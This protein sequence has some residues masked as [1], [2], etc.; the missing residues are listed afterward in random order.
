M[1]SIIVPAYNEEKAISETIKEIKKAMD[2]YEYEI[3]VI[4]DCSK[5]KTGAILTEVKGIRV[6]NHP[7]N[8]GYGS[9]IKSGI[10][11]AKGDW[12]FITDAD[13]TYPIRDM[14]KLI[15]YIKNYD[16]V[17]GSR[18][19]KQVRIPLLRKPAKILLNIL[20]RFL[21][22]KK[23]PDLN[24]GLRIFK[25][26]IALEFFHLFPSKFSFTTT[27]T[28]A[29]LT[30][31]YT[32]KYIPIEYY[33]RKG[34][35]SIK[36][37]DFVNFLT[38]IT[39]IITYFKPFKVFFLFSAIL[40]FIAILVFLYTGIVLNKIMDITVIVLLIASLQIFLWGLIAELIVKTKERK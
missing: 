15:P 2:Y 32:V 5:D 1:I 8:L 12:I 11:I 22:G 26:S 30:N 33:K 19:K 21:T 25:K 4:N 34:K 29:C 9:S 35:S 13:G 40:F 39:R 16:M 23:I 7:Y 20:A 37:V 14:P 17:V 24:S 6:I 10:K 27:I 38:L 18:T 3:I 31:D 36:A 28:L